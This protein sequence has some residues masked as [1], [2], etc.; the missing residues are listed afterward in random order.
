MLNVALDGVRAFDI[1]PC[2]SSRVFLSPPFESPWGWSWW[3]QSEPPLLALATARETQR[4]GNRESSSLSVGK[5]P[6]CPSWNALQQLSDFDSRLGKCGGSLGGI[7]PL[8]F[9]PQRVTDV[10]VH[11]SQNEPTA[12]L[13]GFFPRGAVILVSPCSGEHAWMPQGTEYQIFE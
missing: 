10:F 3:A 2:V 7:Q 5:M 12:S 4:D 8:H 6:V 9:W 13:Q 11:N 1:P